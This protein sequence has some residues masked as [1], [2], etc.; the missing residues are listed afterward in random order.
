[1]TRETC[2]TS[3]PLPQRSVEMRILEF[4]CLNSSMILSLSFCSILPC[5]QDT[6]KLFFIISFASHS[7]LLMLLQNITAWVIVKLS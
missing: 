6:V 2:W 3:K 7:T 1:M 4:P 5:M